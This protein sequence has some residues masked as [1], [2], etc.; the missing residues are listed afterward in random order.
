MQ[1]GYKISFILLNYKT[2]YKWLRIRCIMLIL[3][4]R[5]KREYNVK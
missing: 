1:L 2:L 3:D 4:H 5:Y